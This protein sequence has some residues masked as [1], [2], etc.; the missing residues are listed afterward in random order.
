MPTSSPLPEGLVHRIEDAATDLLGIPFKHLGRSRSGLDCV[1]VLVTVAH[2]VGLSDYDITSYSHRAH[3]HG[4]LKHFDEQLDHI[5]VR[6]LSGGDILVT[7][8]EDEALPCHC[9]IVVRR[10]GTLGFV[11]AWAR[12]RKVVESLLTQ[13][14]P[15]AVRAY[16]FRVDREEVL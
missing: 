12:R 2:D 15:F 4:L 6:D 3:G 13:W 1:G 7:R 10:H 5:S 11:H 16:R 14:R 8:D 9:G